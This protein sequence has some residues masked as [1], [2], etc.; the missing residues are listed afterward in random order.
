[1]EWRLFQKKEKKEAVAFLSPSP[2]RHHPKYHRE[3]VIFYIALL[4]FPLL[5]FCIFYLGVNTN[6]VVL[7]FQK[8]GSSGNTFAGWSNFRAIIDE[9]NNTS[10]LKDALKNSIIIWFFSSITGTVLAILFSYY[11]YKRHFGGAFFRYILFVPSILPAILLVIIFKFFANEAVPGYLQAFFGTV[12]DP[13]LENAN[14]R[15][16]AVIFYNVWIGFGAQILLYTGAME[17]ISPEV[18]EA[19][20]VD[21]ASPFR[22][23]ISIVVPEVWPTIATFLIAGIATI[24]TSQA[25]LFSFFGTSAQYS[26]YTIGYYLFV[27]VN[28][29]D[30]GLSQYPYASALGVLCTLLAVPLTLVCKRFLLGKEDD[31]GA[32][33]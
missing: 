30:Y 9:W 31:A 20:E 27:L 23:M 19:G 3:D 7:A 4:V 6:S 10:I 17:Q 13:L 18:I 14:T 15:M 21:G 25:N 22:E 1:M 12:L 33:A 5:Q 26:D 28:N 2:K 32:H 8:Y 24:F 11:I 29:P 16:G